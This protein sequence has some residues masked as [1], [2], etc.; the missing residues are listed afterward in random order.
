M[1]NCKKLYVTYTAAHKIVCAVNEF[2]VAL[3]QLEQEW[4]INGRMLI[5]VWWAVRRRRKKSPIGA[6]QSHA[7]KR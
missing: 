6:N 4:P 5:E 2:L 3:Q 7:G 1:S